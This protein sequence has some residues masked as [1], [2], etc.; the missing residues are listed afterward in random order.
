MRSGRWGGGVVYLDRGALCAVPMSLTL[1]RPLLVAEARWAA[2]RFHHVLFFPLKVLGYVC[3]PV[4]WY[5]RRRLRP[6]PLSEA[7]EAAIIDGAFAALIAKDL[8]RETSWPDPAQPASPSAAAPPA[9]AAA[10]PAERKQLPPGRFW[11]RRA[12]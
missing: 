5:V 2:A 8:I 6:P 12:F 7:E 4:V 1:Y 9:L 3:V 11:G 10:A